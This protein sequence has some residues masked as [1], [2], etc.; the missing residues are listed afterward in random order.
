MK[1]IVVDGA[2]I[3]SIAARHGFADGSPIIDDPGNDAL[4]KI[5]PEWNQLYPGDEVFIPP[6]KPELLELATGTRHKIVI[7]RT[8]RPPRTAFQEFIDDEG[9]PLSGS[10]DLTVGIVQR[11][12]LLDD[13]MDAATLKQL[14][15][16]RGC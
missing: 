14:E 9:E 7:K 11:R 4:K 5:R 10:Y 13:E 2:C 6:R 8:M 3:N 12:G 1:Y 15:S 16:A